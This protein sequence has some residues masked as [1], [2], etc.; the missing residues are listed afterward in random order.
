MLHARLP[1]A[2]VWRKSTISNQEGACVEVAGLPNAIGIRDSKHPN[3]PHLT[4]SRQAFASFAA[5]VKT[6]F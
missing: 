6:D 1:H 5:R 3:R 4:V 2:A